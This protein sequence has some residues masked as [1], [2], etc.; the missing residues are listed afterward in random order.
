MA[1]TKTSKKGKKSNLNQLISVSTENE[2]KMSLDL[3][4]KDLEFPNSYG[5]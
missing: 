4:A 1:P 2:E 5:C 3:I